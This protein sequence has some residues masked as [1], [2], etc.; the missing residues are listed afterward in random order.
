[1]PVCP[2]TAI[3]TSS[4]GGVYGGGSLACVMG[5]LGA[6]VDTTEITPGS[7]FVEMVLAAFDLGAAVGFAADFASLFGFDTGLGCSVSIVS[8]GTEAGF[9]ASSVVLSWSCG[10][11]S[12][13]KFDSVSC[14]GG[15][16]SVVSAM[17]Y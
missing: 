2:I 14:D 12:D 6:E 4:T 9:I 16:D 17:T 8:F 1:M 3:N 5:S 13:G 11:E 7:L 15:F 10:L